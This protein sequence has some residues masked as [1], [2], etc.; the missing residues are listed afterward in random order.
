MTKPTVVIV[1]GAFCKGVVFTKLIEPLTAH[2][3]EVIALDNPTIGR[4]DPDPPAT[5]SDDAANFRNV[6]TKLADDGKD[7]V[8]IA[9]SYGGMVATEGAKDLGKD[10]R[11]AAGKEGGIVR[12]LYLAAVVAP[13]GGSAS[14]V[15]KDVPFDY[16]SFD[17]RAT[18][19]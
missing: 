8:V 12:L 15:M 17:V 1:P 10:D 16:V 5:L 18:G 19:H 14:S 13:V 7:V 4:R 3:Y 9:H 6:I 11:K 2:G